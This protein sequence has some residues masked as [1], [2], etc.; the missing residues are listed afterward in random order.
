M[1]FRL[2]IIVTPLLA[3]ACGD[4]SDP[5]K[6][7][8]VVADQRVADQG[9]APDQGAAPDHGTTADQGQDAESPADLQAADVPPVSGD[10]ASAAW[11]PPTPYHKLKLCS[12]PP[13]DPSAPETTDL[14]GTWTQKI[15]TQSQT[16]NPLAQAMKKELQ[17][18]NVQTLTGQ[19]ILRSGECVYK[20]KIGGPVVGVIKGNV[21]ITCEVMP[22]TSGVTPLVEGQVTFNGNTGSGPAWTYL[23]DVPLPPSS[24]QA[25]CTVDLKRE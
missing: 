18:G 8:A 11:P 6:D 3:A 25:N 7:S 23:F 19:T 24:C 13:C 15:T 16:C 10:G 20:N 14:S 5:A 1:R 22:V 17:P 21:M 4:G 2:L 9:I 12:L